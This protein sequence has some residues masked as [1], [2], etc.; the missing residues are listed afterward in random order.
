M[1]FRY[2]TLEKSRC[3]GRRFA[4]AW[5][6]GYRIVRE[7]NGQYIPIVLT[8]GKALLIMTDTGFL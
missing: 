8:P 4:L 2:G 6:V 7:N 1:I 5:L 3:F